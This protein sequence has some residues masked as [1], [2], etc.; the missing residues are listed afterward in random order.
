M[1]EGESK[2]RTLADS[3]RFHAERLQLWRLCHRAACRRARSCPV[4]LDCG[5]RF[6]EWAEAVQTAGQ[7]ERDARDPEAEILRSELSRRLNRLAGTLRDEP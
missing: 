4:P 5:R 2:E 3:Y 6:A 7:R 1:I